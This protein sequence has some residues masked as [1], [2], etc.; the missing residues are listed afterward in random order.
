LG[1]AFLLYLLWNI[2]LLYYR[3]FKIGRIYLANY[4]S[5]FELLTGM[6][7]FA[8]VNILT[9]FSASQLYSDPFVLIMIGLSS[10]TFLSVPFLISKYQRLVKGLN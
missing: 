5:D 2:G 9:F 3:N 8:I 7:V 6:V 4:S 10:G 1:S